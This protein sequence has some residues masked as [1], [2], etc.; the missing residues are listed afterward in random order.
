M[1]H[2]MFDW[3]SSQR[4]LAGFRVWGWGHGL[5]HLRKSL[6]EALE[7]PFLKHFNAGSD[8]PLLDASLAF[9][10][11]KQDYQLAGK[12]Q[13]ESGAKSWTCTY[14]PRLCDDRRT[15]VLPEEAHAAGIAG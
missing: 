13:S 12:I 5:G 15:E 14:I 10:M 11:L 8:P 6:V 9:V 4:V 1:W 7:S 2:G 3:K